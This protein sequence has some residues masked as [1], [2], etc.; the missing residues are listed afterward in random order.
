MYL[1]GLEPSPLLHALTNGKEEPR[2]Q[3]GGPRRGHRQLRRA[4]HHGHD[5][6]PAPRQQ[7]AP[8]HLAQCKAIS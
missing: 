7:R 6:G 1:P 3:L 2:E 4:A 8:G 5:Q